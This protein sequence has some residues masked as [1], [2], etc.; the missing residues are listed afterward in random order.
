MSEQKQHG[1]A[2]LVNSDLTEGRGVE[3]IKCICELE[4]TARRLSRQASTQGTDGTVWPV[5]LLH[6]NGRTYGP[7]DLT[8]AT[9]QDVKAQQALDRR[10]A[11]VEKA[12]ALGMSDDEIAELWGH[13]R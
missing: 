9:E 4:A 3:R 7:I 11:L 1:W 2:V 8:L 10:Y 12:K 13:E 6:H 5:E